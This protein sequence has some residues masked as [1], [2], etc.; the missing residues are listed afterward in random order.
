[1]TEASSTPGLPPAQ[2]ETC[3][4]L[5]RSFRGSEVVVAAAQAPNPHAV[6]YGLYAET[7]NVFVCFHSKHPLPVL[8][9]GNSYGLEGITP[10][11]CSCPGVTRLC[12]PSLR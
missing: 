1:M 6:L 12:Q 5:T 7:V 9:P 8:L 2:E 11:S 3:F 4:Q 10:Q